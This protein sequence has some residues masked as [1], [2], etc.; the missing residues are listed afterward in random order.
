MHDT[1]SPLSGYMAKPPVALADYPALV[2]TEVG[3]SDW[4]T[5]DQGMIDRFADLTGDRQFIH[6]DP[7]AAARTP[8][9]G[10]VVHGFLTLSLLGALGPQIIPPVAGTAMG[11]NYGFNRLRFVAPVRSGRRVRAR[12]TLAAFDPKGPGQYLSTFAVT[13]EIEGESKPALLADWL[14]LS[15]LARG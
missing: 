6:V 2:G 9:G 8:L 10:T 1:A 3:V 13:V 5:L 14:T 7:V 15:V 4:I 11:F 12:L